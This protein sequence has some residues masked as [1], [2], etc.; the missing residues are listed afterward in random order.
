MS[1]PLISVIVPVYNADRWLSR[2][3]DSALNQSLHDI[4]VICVDDGSADKSRHVLAQMTEL[5]SRIRPV[6]FDEHQGVSKARNVA[7][8]ISKGEYVFFLDADDWIDSNHLEAMYV[9]VK[10][11]NL[12]VL[13]NTSYDMVYEDGRVEPGSHFRYNGEGLVSYPSSYVQSYVLSALCF[14]MYRLSYLNRNHVRFPLI[15]GGGEDA[16]FT[17]LAEVYKDSVYIMNGPCYH[18]FQHDGSVVHMRDKAFPY[19]QNY[20]ALYDELCA[21][22]ISC[23]DL[24]MLYCGVIELDTREKFNFVKQY[25]TKIE[26]IIQNHPEY[27]TGHDMVLTD[28]VLSCPDYDSF[29]QHHHPNIAIEYVRSKMKKNNE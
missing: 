26:P 5:D 4:E 2:C 10:E 19:I 27:Y 21:R 13:I 29:R 22:G 20:N 23:K 18:Y 8:D 28:I 1:N 11:R 25:I 16:Y 3:L 7:L 15:A 9:H 24:K 17:S 12:D 6:Y 14:R